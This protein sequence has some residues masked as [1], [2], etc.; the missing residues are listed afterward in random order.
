MGCFMQLLDCLCLCKVVCSTNSPLG[1][2]CYI[3]INTVL[4]RGMCNCEFETKKEIMIQWFLKSSTVLGLQWKTNL[5][6]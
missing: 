2:L 1:F 4:L 3:W 6:T 5:S